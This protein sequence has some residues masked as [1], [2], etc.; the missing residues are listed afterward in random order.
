[1]RPSFHHFLLLTT[2]CLGAPFVSQAQTDSG[3]YGRWS[4]P[5]NTANTQGQM[6]DLLKALNALIVKGEKAQA[7]DHL[8]LRDLKD[9]AARYANPWSQRLLFDDFTDGD[10]IRNPQW[11]VTSGEFWVERGYGLRSKV[12]TAGQAQSIAPKMNE[13]QLALSILSSLLQNRSKTPKTTAPKQPTAALTR[14]AVIKTRTSIPNAFAVTTKLSSWNTQGRFQ[15]AVTQGGGRVG[16][17]V[18][19]IP[20]IVG[21]QAQVELIKTTTRGQSIIDAAPVSALED[22]R[23]HPLTWTRRLNGVMTVSIDG[24]KAITTQDQSFRNGFNALTLTSAGTDVI[25]R[26]IRIMGMR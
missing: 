17:A 13:K 22:K 21:G 15:V 26:S 3:R 18:A 7:A 14:P 4:P 19:Y 23:T 2:L 16:Y 1:M 8:F 25:V 24:K 6:K 9:L 12:M 20:A 5:E 10:Y 11:S